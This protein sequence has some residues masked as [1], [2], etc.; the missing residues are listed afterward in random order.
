M[1]D[2]EQSKNSDNDK[3]GTAARIWRAIDKEA[4]ADKADKAKRQAEYRAR[5][6][7]R[8]AVDEAGDQ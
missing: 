7:L 6:N 8:K 4:I 2:Q 1:Q 5:Q 3:I